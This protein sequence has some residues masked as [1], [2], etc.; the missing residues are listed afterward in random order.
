M[1]AS[2]WRW[3]ATRALALLRF[4]KGKRVPPQIQ[5]MRAEDLL[6]SVFPAAT[7][8]QD[9]HQGETLYLEPPDHPLVNETIRDCLTEAMDIDGLTAILHRMESGSLQCVAIDTPAPSVFCHEILNANPYAYLDDAPLEERR[10]RAVE[11]RRTLP[12]ELA[13]QLGALDPD[14]I[15]EVAAEAWPVVRDA[16]ELHDALLTLLWIPD[17]EIPEAWREFL[18]ILLKENRCVVRKGGYLPAERIAE[19]KMLD[20]VRGWMES[21]GPTTAD[22]LATRLQLSADDVHGAL[23]EL[24]NEGQVLRGKFR[25][26]AASDSV[27]WCDRRLLARIHRLTIGRLRKA[28]EPITAADFM[29]FLFQWQ[30]LTPGSR[31]HGEEGLREI[32][33]QLAGF[34]AA[35]GAWE[36][37]ILPL[38]MSK[39][40]PDLLDRLCLGGATMWS[41]LSPPQSERPSL[42]SVAA[43]SLFPRESSDWLHRPNP[44]RP[45]LGPIAE[46]VYLYLSEHG[47]SFSLDISR[48]TGL[49][50]SDVEEGLWQLT[51]AGMLTA[52]GFENLRILLTRGH[53]RV[54]TLNARHRVKHAA[55]RWS[56]LPNRRDGNLQQAEPIARQLL[57]RYGIV[58]RDLLGRESMDVAWRDLLVQYRRMELRGEI[59]GGRFVDG[60]VGEQFALPEAVESARALRR[61][62]KDA[63]TP[64]IKISAA[65]PLNLLG[66][67][68]PGPRVSSIS[69]NFIVLRNG[70][71]VTD[72]GASL[73]PAR[74][75]VKRAPAL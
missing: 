16:D 10:A 39:Y 67:I 1:F 61:S 59:R 31:L 42:T 12:P 72:E 19:F 51:A 60:F 24:E 2:R 3:N 30:H 55:G 62:S 63:S 4:A 6:A 37:H 32:I 27:E 57:K 73:P 58:F 47:A 15:A 17:S 38:R 69:S 41:R 68:L 50:Q 28:I 23:L 49:S 54:H 14:A 48:S 65:D 18:P 44:K 53:R 71:L 52:D 56:L 33:D 22:Q 11:M 64:Q 8:C 9:N 26:S 74:A 75:A 20:I 34:E 13:G 5:R 35:A 21:T 36:R 7:A 46:T 25:G 66:I 45:D 40:D 29:N 43:I 70:V